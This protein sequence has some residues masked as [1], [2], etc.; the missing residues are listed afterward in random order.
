MHPRVTIFESTASVSRHLVTSCCKML[1]Q[2]E[3]GIPA[4]Q[5][6]AVKA[7]RKL[8]NPD[9]PGSWDTAW[10]AGVTPWDAGDVQPPLKEVIEG[11]NDS[12]DWPRAGLALVP[13]CGSGYD[14]VYLASTLGLDVTGLD[15]SQTAV[16]KATALVTNN[17]LQKGS[18]HFVFADF[19]KYEADE[20]V[21]LVY[22]YTFFVA[23]P[24]SRRNEWGKKMAELIAP[25]G[26]LITLVFPIDPHTDLGPPFYVRPEHYNEP[27]SASFEK[28]VDRDPT[29]S[30]PTH[31]GRER[32]L[33]WKRKDN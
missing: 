22:D 24:P 13:G 20:P 28:I 32:L 23:I 27:L 14:V 31:A 26:Y 5:S 19:F 29:A 1:D 9:V 25:G 33:V 12:I 4:A 8:V 30:A 7:M 2:F 6:E 10:K 16:D 21:K 17:P 3:A 18:A 15:M 11:G